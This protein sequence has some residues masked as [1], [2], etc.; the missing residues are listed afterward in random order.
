MKKEDFNDMFKKIPLD[1]R[2]RVAIESH[3]LVEGG[4]SLLMPLDENGNDIPEVA[5]HN[6]K[7]LDKA[8]PIVELVL[9]ELKGWEKDGRP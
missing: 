8:K 3:F 1:V 5:E 2:L 9:E 4:G 7:C 6:R